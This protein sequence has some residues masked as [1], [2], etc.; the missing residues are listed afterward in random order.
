[1]PHCVE[2]ERERER[3]ERSVSERGRA[4]VVCANAEEEMGGVS[5]G[6]RSEAGRRG[7]AF[8]ESLS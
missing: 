4:R 8:G 1:M 5:E 2:R 3:E 7:R 6:K